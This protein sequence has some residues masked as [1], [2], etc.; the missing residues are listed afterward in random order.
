LTICNLLARNTSK[1]PN[2]S[3]HRKCSLFHPH[4]S[5]QT[6]DTVDGL[7]SLTFG[8]D[9]DPAKGGAEPA[10][11]LFFTAGIQKELHGLFGTITPEGFPESA[12]LSS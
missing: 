11:T 4:S 9:R 1:D 12:S 6:L 5:S 7:W 10:N 3:Q 2:P 8:N